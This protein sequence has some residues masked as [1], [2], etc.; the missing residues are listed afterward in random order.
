MKKLLKAVL[1]TLL[2]LFVLVNVI[3][4]IH[5]YKFTHIYER[6]E[7]VVKN[8]ADKTAWD[9][10]SEILF[11]IKVSKQ[12]N[13]VPDSAF[14]TVT[15]TT[16]DGIKLDAWYIKTRHRCQRNSDTFSRAHQ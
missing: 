11:G 7:I 9:K 8:N 2:V 3:I 4:A 14:E 6:G 1:K 10:T 13:T 12:Q 5:A 15:L 16:K